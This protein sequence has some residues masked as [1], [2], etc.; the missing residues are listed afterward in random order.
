[1]KIPIVTNT[2]GGFSVLQDM[3]LHIEFNQF[4]GDG[5]VKALFPASSAKVSGGGYEV[6]GDVSGSNVSSDI[7]KVIKSV[8]VESESLNYLLIGLGAALFFLIWYLKK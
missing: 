4:D 8:S 1:M 7:S 5:V 3:K 6:V 2:G